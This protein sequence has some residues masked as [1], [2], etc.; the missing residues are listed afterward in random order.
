MSSIWSAALVTAPR[1][2]MYNTCPEYFTTSGKAAFTE[3]TVLI[4]L[5]PTKQVF[6]AAKLVN[7][8]ALSAI[9]K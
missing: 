4:V 3:A 8:P 6:V 5:L 2:S 1:F 7:P 9:G